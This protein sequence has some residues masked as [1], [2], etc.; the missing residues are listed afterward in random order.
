MVA[1]RRIGL[2][3]GLSEREFQVACCVVDGDSEAAIGRRLD[4]SKFTVH[5]HLERLYRK[6]G[7]GNR[8]ALVVRLFA[9]YVRLHP[10]AHDALPPGSPPHSGNGVG[11]AADG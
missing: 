9:T 5:T 7:V 10:A 6:L 11:R 2:A 1:W 3:L 8:C 4:I